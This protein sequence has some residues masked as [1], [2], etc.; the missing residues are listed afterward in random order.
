MRMTFET[1]ADSDLPGAH[2][3]A[4]QEAVKSGLDISVSSVVRRMRQQDRRDENDEAAEFAEELGPASAPPPAQIHAS[5]PGGGINKILDVAE[6]AETGSFQSFTPKQ[7]TQMSQSSPNMGAPQ[8]GTDTRIPE[9]R[10]TPGGSPTG[11]E[12]RGW[13]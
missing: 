6:A 7:N 11:A 10:V 4:K 3:Y 8:M 2:I 12:R 1:I 5:E 9:R 13:H